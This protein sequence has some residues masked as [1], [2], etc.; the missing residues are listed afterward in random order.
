MSALVPVNPAQQIAP[1]TLA[2]SLAELPFG[3]QSRVC[4]QGGRID[5]FLAYA[6]YDRSNGTAKYALRVLNNTPSPAHAK[7]SCVRRDGTTV[8]AYPLEFE[9]APYALR[10]D[11][12][13]VRVDVIGDFRH[14]LVEISSAQTYFTVDA[15]APGP[16][17]RP[18]FRWF[19]VA[20]APLVLM[21]ATEMAVPRILGVEAP[22]KALAGSQ[23]DVPLQVSGI[24][25]VEYDF[26]TRDGVQLA[27]GLVDRSGVVRLKI[28][29][30]GG[31]APY[32]LHVRM[33]NAFVG[34][35]QAETIGAIVPATPKPAPPASP[36]I[37]ELA[38]SPSTVHAG[39]KIMVQYASN[40]RAG[41]VWLL[42]SSGRTWASAALSAS[43]ETALA[44]PQSAGGRD[45]RVVVHAKM[46]RQHAQSSVAL[47]VLPD[48]VAAA[49]VPAPS[50]QMQQKSEPQ[51]ILSSQV[52]T[53]GDNV[54]VR[55]SGMPGD[56]RVSL[57]DAAGTTLEQG[58]TSADSGGVTITAP[59]VS[60]VTTYYI[61]AAFSNG[62]MEQSVVR[63]LVV[64]PR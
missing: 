7:L 44:I 42:D 6:G 34:T 23:I 20:A 56:V 37:S 58:D 26:T 54:T 27:A 36:Q 51:I 15:P 22:A 57:M 61:V 12:I 29:S 11:L 60:G 45:L 46:G 10:D 38:V 32:A 47:T 3:T 50:A 28:P 9:I 8:S 31:G 24:G 17:P 33:R 25:T 63:H 52:V 39:D 55:V 48:A 62:T 14:A 30:Y 13:P 18:W 41:D 19:A 49:P 4:T 43:G 1:V 21:G 5:A 35:Q 53:P 59:S 64:T 2:S 40:A 16:V